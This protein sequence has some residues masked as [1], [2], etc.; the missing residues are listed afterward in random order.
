MKGK[1]WNIVQTILRTA[2]GDGM[3]ME[4]YKTKKYKAEEWLNQK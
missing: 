1:K 3:E 4:M 2:K